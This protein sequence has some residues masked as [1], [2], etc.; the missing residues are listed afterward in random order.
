MSGMMGG[1]SEAAAVPGAA[2]HVPKRSDEKIDDAAMRRVKRIWQ[3]NSYAKTLLSRGG[4]R[5]SVAAPE[6]SYTSQLFSAGTPP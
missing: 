1:G 4:L 2:P 6:K 3:T 5:S